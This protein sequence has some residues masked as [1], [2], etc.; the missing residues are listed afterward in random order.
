MSHAPII[1]II[2]HAEK[3]APERGGVAQSGED[4]PHSLAVRGWQRAGALVGLFAPLERPLPEPRLARPAYLFAECADAPGSEEKHS[5]REEQTFIPLAAML[6][7]EPSF[8]FGKVQEAEAAAAAKLCPGA[9][10]MAWEHK[11][12]LELAAEITK[13]EELPPKWPSDRYDLVMVFR[14]QADGETYSFEQVP[15][16]LLA[17]DTG[18]PILG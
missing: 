6:G 1:M 2:R 12:L 13:S 4:D 9:V 18:L 17:G 7:I 5:Q 16:L 11:K 8:E 10:L 14:L 15:Q 3:A